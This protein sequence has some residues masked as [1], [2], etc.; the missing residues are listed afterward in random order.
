MKSKI[1]ELEEKLH[2]SQLEAQRYKRSRDLL[3]KSRS[4]LWGIIH[5]LWSERDRGKWPK[6]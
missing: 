1:K 6:V 2:L 5:E 3:R 4:E